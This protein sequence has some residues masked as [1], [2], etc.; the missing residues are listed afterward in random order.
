MN[1]SVASHENGKP[2]SRDSAA[3]AALA[4]IAG[5]LY[6]I[7]LTVSGYANTFYAMAAQA[8]SQSWSAL[9]FGAL[10]VQGFITT[11]KPPLATA[12]MGLSVKAF[13][14]SSWSIL[15]PEALLGVGSVVVLFLAVR[16]SFGSTAGLIAGVLMA[17]SPAAVLI[18]RY[19]NPDALLT[20]LL[21]SAAWAL[22]R[23]LELGRLRWALLS[24][25]LVGAAFLTKYLQ[26]YL[27]LPAS[28]WSGSCALR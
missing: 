16:R 27:V 24:A 22:L 12:L 7:N 9:F 28:R 8:A 1:L 6:L 3:I 14:L 25:S 15:V 26:A 20:F 18:F 11:D 17:V 5:L 2:I 23:G 19:D 10:D 13:G 21:V 4:L